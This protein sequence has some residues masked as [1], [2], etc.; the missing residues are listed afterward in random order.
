MYSGAVQVSESTKNDRIILCLTRYHVK[1]E[2][3]FFFFYVNLMFS[4][5]FSALIGAN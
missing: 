4:A 3:D 2:L 1:L 5:G